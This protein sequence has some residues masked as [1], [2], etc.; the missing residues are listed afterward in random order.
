MDVPE[1]PSGVVRGAGEVGARGVEFDAADAG[2]MA[3][4]GAEGGFLAQ[5]PEVDVSFAAAGGEVDAV[6]RH[7]GA[8]E[9]GVGVPRNTAYAVGVATQ[10]FGLF[11]IR[12]GKKFYATAPIARGDGLAVGGEA[13]DTDGTV[14]GDLRA[15]ER[16]L[17]EP[18]FEGF[19]VFDVCA[20]GDGGFEFLSRDAR[21][22]FRKGIASDYASSFEKLLDAFSIEFFF[23]LAL[24]DRAALGRFAYLDIT[25]VILI[26]GFELGA[27]G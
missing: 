7:G 13:A 1:P 2:G 18:V 6:L 10:G 17:R 16:V 19:A 14:A 23:L 5:G 9:C 12:D 25:R 24:V 22:G 4:E 3:G 21:F 27:L 26:A 8:G 15:E 11:E 20:E